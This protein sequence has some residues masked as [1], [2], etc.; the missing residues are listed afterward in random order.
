MFTNLKVRTRLLAGFGALLALMLAVVAL[1]FVALRDAGDQA[2]A[3]A[4]H[5]LVLAGAASAM[6]AAQLEQAVAIRDFVAQEDVAAEKA[7]REAMARSAKAYAEA[8]GVL[9]EQVKGYAELEALAA[10]LV[11][12]QAPVTQKVREVMEM[13]ENAEYDRARAT[14]YKDLLPLQR[15]V[16]SD[17]GKLA[18]LT[19]QAA[20]QRADETEAGVA[21]ALKQI[22]LVLGVA[23]VLGVLGAHWLARSVTRPLGSALAVTERVAAGDLSGAI[24]SGANDETGRVLAALGQMQQSLH[25]MAT[26]IRDGARVVSEAAEEISKGNNQLSQRTEEQASALQQ[27]VASVEQITATVKQNAGNAASANTVAAEAAEQAESGGQTVVRLVDTMNRIQGSSKRMAD[28]VGVIDGIAFQTNILALNAAVEAARAGEQ[29]RGFAVVAAEVR[30][31]AQRS[32]TAAKEVKALIGEGVEQAASGTKLADEA[33][34]AISGIV[35]AAKQVSGFVADIA[36]ASAEQRSGIE[37]IS[38]SLTQ[39]D[40]NTQRNA[41]LVEETNAA[42]QALLDQ[43]KELVGVVGRFKLEQAASA[44][45]TVDPQPLAEGPAAVIDGDSAPRLRAAAPLRP[46]PAA[47]A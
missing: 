34:K 23:V 18:E 40:D 32:A 36:S 16:V 30:G 8:A 29:G 10:R 4:Q 25:G 13:V 26:G 17:L 5:E 21:Q 44:A 20:K 39:M 2:A 41:G 27:V 14:V 38:V 11:S 37:Q 42:T 46:A 35:A 1:A 33:G 43:A 6:Q 45:I 7:A 9:T 12:A 19:A 24:E 28:I 22:A 31:L 3:L 47:S 15:A